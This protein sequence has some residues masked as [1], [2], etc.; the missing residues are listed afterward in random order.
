MLSAASRFFVL[1]LIMF[2]L[3]FIAVFRSQKSRLKPT[4]QTRDSAQRQKGREA[5]DDVSG[6]LDADKAFPPPKYVSAL[7]P[8]GPADLH[9]R[10][11]PRKSAKNAKKLR[12][13]DAKPQRRKVQRH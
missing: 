5:I 13:S 4:W 9:G 7:R 1:F 10:E 2:I 8:N 6:S 11:S 12:K 3:M